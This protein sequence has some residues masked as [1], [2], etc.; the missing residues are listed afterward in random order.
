MRPPEPPYFK[1]FSI[2]L[3]KTWWMA[4]R[5]ASTMRNDSAEPFCLRVHDFQFYSVRARDLAKT[6]FGVVQQFD[7]RD[8]FEHRSAFRR[9][10]RA[11]A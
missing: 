10:P 5:S 11:L 9:T 8:G 6:F 1:A 2:R 3:E 4:S 7:G